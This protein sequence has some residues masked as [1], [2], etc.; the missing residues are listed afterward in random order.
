MWT[1]TKWQADRIKDIKQTLTKDRCHAPVYMAVGD[2]LK[3]AM[4]AREVMSI[5]MA[6]DHEESLKLKTGTDLFTLACKSLLPHV[7]SE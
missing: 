4:I 7:W 6:V 2:S 1:L 3:E 5:M